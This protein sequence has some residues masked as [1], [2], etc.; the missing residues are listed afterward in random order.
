[1]DSYDKST[2]PNI[3]TDEYVKIY[4]KLYQQRGR[5]PKKAELEREVSEYIRRKPDSTSNQH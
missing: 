4:D 2:I 3:S 1:M 5:P